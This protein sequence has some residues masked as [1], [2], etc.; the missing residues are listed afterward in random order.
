MAIEG[1]ARLLP[2]KIFWEPSLN[3][4]LGAQAAFLGAQL[5]KI[6][7]FITLW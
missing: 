5:K 7:N 2:K 1:F 3:K 6:S 4:K